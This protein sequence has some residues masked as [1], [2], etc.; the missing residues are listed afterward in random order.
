SHELEQQS[1]RPRWKFLAIILAYTVV[2]KVLPYILYHWGMDVEK[3]F[4]IYPWNFSP[5]FALCLFGGAMYQS[6]LNALWIPLSVMLLGDLG[7]WAVTGKLDWA[8]YPG[9]YVVY[10]AFAMCAIIGFLLKPNKSWTRIA[11]AGAISC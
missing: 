9:Q 1:E 10:I 5:I 4:A 11:G 8:F 6:K 7:I 3:N 2:L